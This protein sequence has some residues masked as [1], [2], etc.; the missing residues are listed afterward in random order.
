MHV[1]TEY[2]PFPV[3]REGDVRFEFVIVFG[4]INQFFGFKPAVLRSEEINPLTVS[5]RSDA[6][7]TTAVAGE[8]PPS[9]ETLKCTDQCSRATLYLI[10]LPV[11][12]S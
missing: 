10:S 6:A 1:R 5:G 9:G 3:Q 7:R 12:S 4:K 11:A 2:D 8:M